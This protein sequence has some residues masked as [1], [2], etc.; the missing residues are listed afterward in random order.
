MM[1][2]YISSSCAV[3]NAPT[4]TAVAGT[5]A[6]GKSIKISSQIRTQNVALTFQSPN[7]NYIDDNLQQFFVTFNPAITDCSVTFATTF[8]A[9]A[10]A[11]FI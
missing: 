8:I 3:F 5:E 9:V 6:T 1:L 7:L 2:Q 4:D 10:F 11:A